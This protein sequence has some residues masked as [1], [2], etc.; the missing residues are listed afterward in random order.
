MSKNYEKRVYASNS[1]TSSTSPIGTRKVTKTESTVNEFGQP[2]TKTTTIC[3]KVVIMNDET[4]LV[5]IL[6]L[7]SFFMIPHF[8]NS[9]HF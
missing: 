7:I 8:S 5:F 2:V 4:V 3:S 1:S 9:V 6:S